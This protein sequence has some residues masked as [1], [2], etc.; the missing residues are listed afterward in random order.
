[1]LNGMKCDINIIGNNGI[2]VDEIGIIGG[3]EKDCV[4]E[5]VNAACAFD[6]LSFKGKNPRKD[7]SY[8][9]CGKN[10]G[11]E[12]GD[13]IVTVEITAKVTSR[14]KVRWDNIAEEWAN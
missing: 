3:D 5:A 8:L 10:F 1:M 13:R 11:R 12:A 7:G 2:S 14:A 6:K 4:W 9:L